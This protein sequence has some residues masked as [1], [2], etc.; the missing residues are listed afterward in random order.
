MLLNPN[1]DYDI[2][3]GDLVFYEVPYSDRISSGYVTSFTGTGPSRVADIKDSEIKGNMQRHVD[4]LFRTREDAIKADQARTEKDYGRYVAT[5]NSVTD[6]VKFAHE[7]VIALS[8]SDTD[9]TARA[10]YEAKAEELLG[11]E[12]H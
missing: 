7:H 4:N 3:I 5:I 12:F 1:P 6:L 8:G 2:E 11:I 9:W 10:A